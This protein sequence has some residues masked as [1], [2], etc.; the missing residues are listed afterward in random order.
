MNMGILVTMS[1]TQGGHGFPAFHNAV[2]DYMVT[3]SYLNLNV[4]SSEVPD[5]SVRSLIEQVCNNDN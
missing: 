2:Y 4:A 5:A 1:I 3:G